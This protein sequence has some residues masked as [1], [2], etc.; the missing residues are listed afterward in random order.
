MVF[1]CF[2]LFVCVF[3]CVFKLLMMCLCFVLLLCYGVLLLF[4]CC[5]FSRN[6]S[7]FRS[8][9]RGTTYKNRN[10]YVRMVVLM[11]VVDSVLN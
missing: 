4:C 6:V 9:S 3:V 11:M 10:Y 8:Y 2:E 1:Y 5:R 7:T